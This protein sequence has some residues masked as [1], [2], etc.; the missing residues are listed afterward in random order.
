MPEVTIGR[1]RGGFCVYWY[2]GSKRRRFE[3]KARTRTEAEAEAVEVYRKQ[4][5]VAA[6]RNLSISEIWALYVEDLGARPTAKTM[7]YT[8]RAVLPHFGSFQPEDV[9]KSLCVKYEAERLK[10]GKSQGTIWTE[11]GHLQSALKFAKKSKIIDD[12]PTIWR[13]SKPESDK[14]I[15][16][17]GEARA[18]TD[19]ARDPH[20][21]LAIILMLTTAARVG[22]LLELTWDRVDF[23]GNSINLRL[24]DAT[25]RKGRANVPMNASARAALSTAHAAAL[26]DYVIEYATGPVKSVRKGFASAVERAKIGHVR[27]HDMRHT[28]AVWMLQKGIRLEKV[29]QYLG[30]SN[31][32][33]TFKTY[34]RYLPEHMQDAADVLDFMSM[35]K[36]K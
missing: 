32:N 9:S 1:L 26:S 25:R 4:T 11:L 8:G 24:P 17:P 22:A 29:S 7:E 27:I 19:A 5:Y 34:A 18:L 6:P 3:L 2:E 30:H 36:A 12:A 21:R 31:T 28:A 10:Q 16:N 23:E 14:R 15:L 35:R 33:I 20:I 13:P